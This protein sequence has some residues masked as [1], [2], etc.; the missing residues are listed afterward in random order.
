M[1]RQ[2]AA[3]E[4]ARRFIDAAVA[5][6]PV[7]ELAG[8]AAWFV[9]LALGGQLLSVAAA[10]VAARVAWGATNALRRDLVAHCLDAGPAF[11]QRHPPG[12]LVDR[13]DGDVTRLAGLL[14]GLLPE[15]AAHLLLIVGILAALFLL[16]WRYGALFLPFALLMLALL[17]RLAGRAVPLLAARRQAGAALVGYLEEALTARED[18]RANGATGHVLAGL[19]A[20]ILAHY[21]AARRAARAAV[22]WPAAVQALAAVNFSAALALGLWLYQ[23]RG[24]SVGTVFAGLSYAVLLRLPLI[25]ITTRFQ[26]VEDVLVSV[27]R[28]DELFA[29][30]NPVRDGPGAPPPGPLAVAFDRVGFGYGEGPVLRGVSFAVPAGRRVALI[31][32]TGSGKST[33]LRLLF[34]QYDP[35]AGAVAVGGADLRGLGVAA[36]RAR[37]AYVTQDVPL[38]PGTLR[39]NLT[40][41]DRRVPDAALVAALADVGLADRCAA[42]PAGLD[43]VLGPAGVGLSGGEEQLVALARA[44][45]AEPDVVL[46]DEP[47][48]RLDPHHERRLHGTLARFLAGRTALVIAH[49]PATLRLVDDV[50]VLDG[51]RV[52]AYGPRDE[53]L[54]SGAARRLLAAG[55]R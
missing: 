46:L 52:A 7:A 21:A 54:G 30:R 48:A 47:S 11:H 17:R 37:L 38:I 45:L 25:S 31:G 4:L 43:T 19:W 24:A 3:P 28:L 40:F 27:R 10:A 23:H 50:L 39:D 22:A 20:R 12:E 18:I 44:L 13:V 8:Y 29:A 5:H 15:I 49:R 36:L 26:D 41:F 33:V 55:E 9:G 14:S 35:D 53:V 16:D 2:L 6:G 42:L 51:G 1:L 32:R 34:R